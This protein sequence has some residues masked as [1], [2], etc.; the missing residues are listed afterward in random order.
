MRSI[1]V[2]LLMMFFLPNWGF[3][4]IE[5][6]KDK[7][8]NYEYLI[9][10]P[11]GY[12]KDKQKKY[13]LLMY[14]H[15][16]SIRGR[17]LEKVKSYGVIYEI[18]R[19]LKIDF[20]VVAPQCQT[21]WEND[22]LIEVLDHAEKNYRVDK[23]KVYLTGMS[24]GGYGAWYL[25]GG[26]PDRFAA[27]APVAGGGKLSDIEDLKS[28]PHWVFHG[29]QDK[30]VPVEESRKM[31]KALKKAGNKKVKYSE[32]KNWD[33]GDAIAAFAMDELYEW[34]LT[35]ERGNIADEPIIVAVEEEPEIVIEE[36]PVIK[37]PEIIVESTAND[38]DYIDFDENP[39]S[40]A[41][42]EPQ[43]PK[44]HRKKAKW[45]QFWKWKIWKEL[46]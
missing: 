21:H 46:K 37:E 11:E 28:M 14:L 12:K 33:H 23:R 44:Q 45:W 10:Y 2:C 29:V 16:R 1:F 9:Y 39:E 18:I 40:K 43:R 32:Y 5:E 22:K 27:V 7:S 3:A 41:E 34:F 6:V 42:P 30:P 19:G 20:I 24:M 8:I 13:P 25:A 36:E 38:E 35:Y 15:G 26:H 31:V 17:D 4:Q